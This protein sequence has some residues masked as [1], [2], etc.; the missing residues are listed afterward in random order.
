[1][2][3]LVILFKVLQKF[4]VLVVFERYPYFFCNGKFSNARY[5]SVHNLHTLESFL[6]R[7]LQIRSFLY[8][9]ISQKIKFLKEIL[10]I[11]SCRFILKW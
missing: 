8:Y 3:I 5:R 9:I 4:F 10:S 6:N 11:L 1:M 2:T 7:I